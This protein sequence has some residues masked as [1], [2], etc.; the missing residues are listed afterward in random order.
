MLLV[1]VPR[2]VGLVA[3][4]VSALAGAN[5][6]KIGLPGKS[7]LEYY[8]QENRTSRRPFLLL[9]I[10]FPGKPIFIQLV[11]ARGFVSQRLLV[12]PVERGH[13]DAQQF[14]PALHVNVLVG[15]GLK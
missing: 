1:N 10:S 11:P 13:G 9:R 5:C 2:E 15:D 4:Q 3:R 12:P 14:G 7:I 8:F 6:I